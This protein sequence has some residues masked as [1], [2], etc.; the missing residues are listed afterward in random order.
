MESVATSE[1]RV[2]SLFYAWLYFRVSY[3]FFVYMGEVMINIEKEKTVFFSAHRT[4]LLD[5]SKRKIKARLEKAIDSAIENGFNTFLSGMSPGVDTW[6]AEIVLKKRKKNKAIRLICVLPFMDIGKNCNPINN[7]KIKLILRNADDIHLISFILKKDCIM[8][9]D[10]F[11]ADHSSHIIVA[12][13]GFN[14]CTKNILN[15]IEDKDIQ[16]TNILQKR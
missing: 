2:T 1:T 7:R 9:R 11:M 4:E 15:Y 12:Y 13:K 8:L 14:G 3:A 5:M 6:A 16:I 10:R